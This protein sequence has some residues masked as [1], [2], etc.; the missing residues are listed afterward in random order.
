MTLT[1]LLWALIGLLLTIGGNF[2]KASIVGL[3][4][5]WSLQGIPAHFLGV[6]YQIGAVLLVGCLG[7]KNAAVISQIAYLGLGLAGF[8]FFMNGGGIGYLREPTFGYLLGFLPGAWL[9]GYLAFRA[10]PRLE[11]LAVCCLSGLATIHAT[12]MLYL[13]AVYGLKL[14]DA[15]KV[16]FVQAIVT[17]SVNLLPGQLAVVCA[18]ALAAYAVRRAMFY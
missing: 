18:I 3:P 13:S 2:L 6:N 17:Y 16:P 7:G 9:C 11:W 8:P 4:W 14:A 15:S 5:T 1:E 12:G 10:A